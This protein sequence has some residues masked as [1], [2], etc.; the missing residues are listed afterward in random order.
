[1]SV[2]GLIIRINLT[3][4]D[5]NNAIPVNKI[6]NEAEC[7]N[8]MSVVKLPAAWWKEEIFS[9]EQLKEASDCKEGEYFTCSVYT[10]E[11]KYDLIYGKR[12]PR[13]QVCKNDLTEDTKWTLDDIRLAAENSEFIRCKKCNDAVTIRIPDEFV[14]SLFHLPVHAIIAEDF[15]QKAD[16]EFKG[17]LMMFAC[18]QCGAS[19]KCDGSARVVSCSYCNSDNFLPQEL[20]RRLHPVPKPKFLFIL[21]E[22]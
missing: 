19:L 6:K 14:K 8:C 1:M 2:I 7:P 11:L 21:A 18:L 9:S 15:D 3:C 13:C 22:L 5:C 10:G 17:E 20:W 4:P 12:F 16:S